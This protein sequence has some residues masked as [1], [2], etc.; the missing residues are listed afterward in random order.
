MLDFASQAAAR[1]GEGVFYRR[2]VDELH[3]ARQRR[4]AVADESRI[5]AGFP[6]DQSVPPRG[7]HF[8]AVAAVQ[9]LDNAA[10]VERQIVAVILLFGEFPALFCGHFLGE[11]EDERLA[12]YQDAVEIEDEGAQQGGT[13][14][15]P[16][17]FPPRRRAA[18]AGRYDTLV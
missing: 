18:P 14:R 8:A 4:Q 13:K 9:A 7:I 16:K 12:V 1:N 6:G 15:S 3:G 2:L 11:L 10:V 5:L 17:R